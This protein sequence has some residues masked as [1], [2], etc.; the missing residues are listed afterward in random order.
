MQMPNP[1]CVTCTEVKLSKAPYGPAL[2]KMTKVGELMHTDIWGRYEKNSIN[3]NHYFLLLINDTSQHVTIKFLKTKD[4]AVQQVKNYLA[5][6]KARGASPCAIKMDLGTEFLNENL[7][8]WCNS[9]G[10]QL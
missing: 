2:V 9:K 7:R 3:G 1:D 6:L 8:S 4:Q 10:I 5:Y